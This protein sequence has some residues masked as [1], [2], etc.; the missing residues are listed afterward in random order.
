[1]FN[2]NFKNVELG[3]FFA[4]E[5]RYL[6]KKA[7]EVIYSKLMGKQL[8]SINSEIPVGFTHGVYHIEDERGRAKWLAGNAKDL[9]RVGSNATE[10]IYP[11]HTCGDSFGITMSELEAA[12]A[13]GRNINDR[14]MK[15]AQKVV[16]RE[17][18]TA[19]FE[20]VPDLDID[21][22]LTN[23]DVPNDQV[24]VGATSAASLWSLKNPDEIAYDVNLAFS[25]TADITD[26]QE[27]PN[28]LGVDIINY[29]LLATTPMAGGLDT[30]LSWLVKT[31]PYLNSMEDV[32]KIPY[33]KGAGNGG[34]NMFMIW[35]PSPDKV[36]IKLPRD[37]TVLSEYTNLEGLEW[38]TPV[39]A[40]FGGLHFYYPKSARKV[41]GI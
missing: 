39:I 25:T 18:D 29:N 14:R 11:I 16:E 22:L 2:A 3:T 9:P 15:I 34:S 27:N 32:I 17:L 20:G 30:I 7:L 5:L 8:F 40:S 38:V 37:T 10:V 33:F 19:I 24:T 1:M 31:S 6:E 28:K 36:E 26:D 13:T 35:D 21:G 12:Q 4:D 23:T 41:W